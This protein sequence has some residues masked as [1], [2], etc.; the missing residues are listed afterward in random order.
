MPRLVILNL[1]D[2]GQMGPVTRVKR[3]LEA[4]IQAGPRTVL[5]GEDVVPIHDLFDEL[6]DLQDGTPLGDKL[7]AARDDCDVAEKIYLCTHGLANDT[8]H[9]FAKASGGE[10]LGTWKDFGRLIRKVLPK[11]SK[12]YKVALVMCYGARTDEY[13]ARDLDHQGMIPLTL[14]NTSFAYKMFHYLCS[15]HGRTMTMTARTGAVGFDDT[16]G[17]SSV[18]QEAAIDIALEKEE[19]LRSPKIDRVMKQWAAYRRAI[20]SDKAAQEWLKIDNK[21]RDDPKAYANPFNK[22]A[23]AGKAYHQALARKIALETQ[24]SAYQDLQK[25]GKL[26]YTHIG[27]TLTIVN[28]YGNNGG[29]GPQTVLY[30]G[31]FL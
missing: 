5:V 13:Y 17:K 16:T 2:P 10:A 7:K 11:R 20:D 6:K 23:V 12:H 22:K 18:E 14:L 15:D 21:Y 19:F 30:T 25:Y 27:G 3:G 4:K 9:A 28:K 26:V 24:K 31:P 29:I 8:E 1:A